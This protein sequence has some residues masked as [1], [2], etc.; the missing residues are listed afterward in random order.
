M[1]LVELVQSDASVAY[2]FI[3]NDDDDYENNYWKQKVMKISSGRGVLLLE[4]KRHYVRRK[5]AAGR[6]VNSLDTSHDPEMFE[7]LTGTT[8]EEFD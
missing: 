2:H 1:A 3:I 4:S 5:G 7:T 8:V 6:F